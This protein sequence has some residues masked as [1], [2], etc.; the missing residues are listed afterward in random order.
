M[1]KLILVLCLVA[2]L[3]LGTDARQPKVGDY[4]RI[5]ENLGEGTGVFYE[6]NITFMSD[7]LICMNCTSAGV[8]SGDMVRGLSKDTYPLDICVG[9]GQISML[10]WLSRNVE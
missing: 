9:T 1:K 10:T 3:I 5:S 8:T 4:V 6:G 7:G 2:L